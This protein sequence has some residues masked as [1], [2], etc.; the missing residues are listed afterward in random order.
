VLDWLNSVEVKF[1]PRADCVLATF[2]GPFSLEELL[3]AFHKTYESATEQGLRLILIDCSGL[4]GMLSTQ[5]RFKLGES[6]VAYWLGKSPETNWLSKPA[7]IRPKIAIV[8]KVPLVDGFGALAASN[9]GV[10]A[11]AFSEVPQAL[12]WLGLAQ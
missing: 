12:G 6:A 1:D 8:G 9:R 2:A 5:E 7:G 11:K 3:E 10:N 4:D